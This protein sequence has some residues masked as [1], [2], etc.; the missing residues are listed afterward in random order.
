MVM[1]PGIRPLALATALLIGVPGAASAQPT[2]SDA[3]AAPTSTT[4]RA[5]SGL[6]TI[7]GTVGPGFTIEVSRQRA[8]KGRYKL[9]VRDNSADHNWH[10]TGPGVDRRT[11]VGGTGRYV[12]RVRLREGTYTI[13]CDPHAS[14]MRTQLRVV[15][16]G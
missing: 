8:P 12:W 2:A 13:V 10:M 6:P 11:P 4:D 15:D 9:V 5:V 7:R 16:P 14:S 3:P 1:L